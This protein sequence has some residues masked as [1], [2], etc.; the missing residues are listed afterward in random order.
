[1]AQ[2]IERKFLLTALPADAGT[3]PVVTLEQGYLALEE[4][5]PEV[6]LRRSGGQCW[7]TV[8]HGSGLVRREYETTISLDQYH[9]LWPATE[10][11]RLRK[12]RYLM[13]YE[14]WPVEIDVYSEPLQGLMVAEVEFPSMKSAMAF[15]PA[16]WM[17]R[18]VTH[19]SFLK[20]RELLKFRS[21]EA[22]RQW[23]EKTL[24]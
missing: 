7:L 14:A 22:L 5:G 12:H 6:R 23:L 2:E 20:N 19:L 15:R 21:A 3:A 13:Q 1:M 24:S 4:N 9:E 8:K 10:G 16:S 18:E 11:R 17:G